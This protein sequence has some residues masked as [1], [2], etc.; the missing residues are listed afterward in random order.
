MGIVTV[1]TLLV[2][3]CRV[4]HAKGLVR[5]HT[6][7]ARDSMHRSFDKL[8][9]KF[10]GRALPA[11][12]LRHANLDKT[13]LRKPSHLPVPTSRAS[14][15]AAFPRLI[16]PSSCFLPPDKPGRQFRPHLDV[17][18]KANDDLWTYERLKDATQPEVKP[19]TSNGLGAEA[20][21]MT[22]APE[23]NKVA[24]VT[25]ASTGIG[26]ATVEGMARSGLYGTIVLAG[27]NAAKHELAVEGL[28]ER[29]GSMA[30]GLVL[31]HM[32][33]ELTSLQ[34]VRA[35]ATDFLMSDSPLHTIVLNAGVMAIPDRRTTEDG[36]E[37]QFGVNHLSHFLLANLL[38]DRL[39]A[40]AS[41]VDPG[42][43]ISLSS[44]AHQI[45]CPLLYGDVEQLQ[46]DQNNYNGWVAYGQ[47]KLCNILFA[48]ELDRRC[49]DLGLPVAANAVH[50][51]GVDTELGRYLVG[52]SSEG[53]G[54]SDATEPLR[55]LAKPF[56][57]LAVKTP[58]DGACTSVMLATTPMG[59]LSG[60]YWLDK[61]PAA[62]LDVD[63]TNELPGPAKA[64]LPVQ[65][66]LTSYNPETW[67]E[68]WEESE[69][70]SGL[71]PDEVTS[72]QSKMPSELQ[73]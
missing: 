36:H 46:L 20:Q 65:P 22:K 41:P 28:K 68:L 21:N 4:A 69:K 31:K 26:L 45:P 62:S 48:Y 58:E 15:P 6:D 5:Y 49:R 72:W 61:R 11:W 66:R 12:P 56:L 39:V 63:P 57:E 29:L 44:A 27:R 25:G 24:I 13:T 59:K 54:S 43:V 17:K 9:D 16:V 8:I 33:L 30:E 23:G 50:P 38:L 34:S 70:L 40:S 35:F 10:L 32:P 53:T 18:A 52:E 60:R 42:R 67:S 47:S 64:F 55:N 2:V 71:K 51:G 73:K 19:S 3:D 7:D 14:P 37:C 1:I